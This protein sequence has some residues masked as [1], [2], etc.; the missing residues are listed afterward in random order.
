MLRSDTTMA[1]CE[2]DVTALEMCDVLGSRMPWRE[3]FQSDSEPE[4]DRIRKLGR[5]S[6]VLEIQV[7]EVHLELGQSCLLRS[8]ELQNY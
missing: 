8:S 1:K 7:P 5:T 3:C 4:T 6:K 2:C